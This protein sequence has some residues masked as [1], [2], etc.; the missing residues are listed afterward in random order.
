MRVQPWNTGWTVMTSQPRQSFGA[1]A[2]GTPVTLPHDVTIHTDPFAAA[3]GGAATGYYGGGE[4]IYTKYFEAPAD[5]QG[6]TVLVRFDGVFSYAEVSINGHLAA[7]H[8]YGYT[9][10]VADLTPYLY[11]HRRNRLEV[12]ANNTAQPNSR[13]Y[14]GTGI[15]RPVELLTGPQL[16]IAPWG[17]FAHTDALTDGCAE[18]TAE[19]TVVN[20]TGAAADRRVYASLSHAGQ[21]LATGFQMVH[22][23]AHGEAVARVHLR[24]PGAPIWDVD[25]P[26]LCT[27]T[28]AVDDDEASTSFGIRTVQIDRTGL[29]LNGRSLKFKG[30]CVHHDNGILGAASFA[31]SEFRKMKLHKDNGYNAI[32]TAHN[33]PSTAMLDACDRLGLLVMDEAFD[34]WRIPKVRNDYHLYFEKYWKEDLAAMIRRDRNHPCVIL[35]STGNEI[36]ERGGLSN[37][38]EIARQLADY[39][40]QLDPTR[41]VLNALCSFFSGLDDEKNERQMEAFRKLMSGETQNAATSFDADQWPALTEPF[42]AP[43][44]VVGYNYF[45]ARYAADGEAFPQRIICGTESFPKE[46]D[47]IWERVE[48]NDHV[49]GDFTWTSFDYIGEAGIGKAAFVEPGTDSRQAMALSFGNA[50]PWRTANDADFDICGFER[51]QL[52]Y[53]RIVWGS[54]ETYIAVHDPAGYGKFEAVSQWGWPQVHNHWNWAGREGQPVQVSVY[55]RAEEVELRLNGVSVGRAPAGKAAR[56]TAKFELPYAP[57][58]LEAVSY[59]GGAELSRQIIATTGAPVGLRITFEP[60][61][62]AAGEQSLAYATV[63]I[64]DA[65][66]RRVPDA[67]LRAEAAVTGAATLQ[68]FAS[69]RPQT[70]E[71][72]TAG[73]FTA[74]EG[75][76]Q[77]ILRAAAEPGAATLRV[78]A[79][80]LPAAEAEIVAG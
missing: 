59:T 34:V 62:F 11:F 74:Y 3:P 45:D 72:Y 9:A 56:Y 48:A 4:G 36:G 42:A 33:P 76:W 77:A 49:I 20:D 46:Y 39:A 79:A 73:A 1:Q 78:T 55:S 50:F 29:R 22:I 41:P 67:A 12:I 30:G 57:G 44:D 23:P 6:Q 32:R 65:E 35:W 40:R 61:V 26:Q 68:A 51:P 70:E 43:L 47:V 52:A 8:P 2:E 60:G 53:R 28:A 16:R 21:T 75:R 71:N 31:D 25:D 18:V 37:G 58:T 14:T 66:G 19:V 7:L 69:A 17:I 5:W 13:W 64:V 80:G 38:Y 24:V 63:E 54:T 15:Y 27:V 10:F